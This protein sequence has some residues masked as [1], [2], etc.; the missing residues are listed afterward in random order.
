MKKTIPTKVVISS[1]LAKAGFD[2]MVNQDNFSVIYP[3]KIWRA[4]NRQAKLILTENMA[5]A[6]TLFLPVMFNLKEIK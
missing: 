5:Y 3:E 1:K 6:S 2:V 4:Y